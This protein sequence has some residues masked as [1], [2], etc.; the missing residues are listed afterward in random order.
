L[1][2]HNGAA[3]ALLA[4]KIVS[5]KCVIISDLW[6]EHAATF[7]YLRDRGRSSSEPKRPSIRYVAFSRFVERD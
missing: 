3:R 4:A 1:Y 6:Y 5:V 2:A 7:L